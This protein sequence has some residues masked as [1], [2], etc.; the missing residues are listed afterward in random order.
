[1][2]F[3]ALNRENM[4][5]RQFLLGAASICA[6]G[7]VSAGQARTFD[8]GTVHGRDLLFRFTCPEIKEDVRLF[9]IGDT[10]IGDDDERGAPYSHF[11]K[12]MAASYS[13]FD[14]RGNLA[15]AARIAAAKKADFIALVGD[16]VS[17][18]SHSGTEYIRRTM[19]SCGVPWGYVAGNH[20]WHYEGEAGS[21]VDLRAK[22]TEKRLKPLYQGENP[23]MYAKSV[24]GM[25]LLFVDD[26]IYQ[27]LPEQLDFLKHELARGEPT[28]LMM[29]V[30]VFTPGR[31][32]SLGAPNWG[33]DTDRDWEIERRE[34][35]PKEGC[36]ET[37]KEFCRLALSAPNMLGVFA[38]HHHVFEMDNV[39]GFTQ[40]V[41][42]GHYK[43]PDSF[44]DISF[45]P[46]AS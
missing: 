4:N 41:T 14:R 40:L 17:Y 43:A 12:R 6:L 8:R 46:A 25:R 10:H 33:W 32:I 36:G 26:S 24:K 15:K 37:T 23:L 29:H 3:N 44:L 11:S 28:A 39:H 20:D 34:R 38:G 42:P 31:G 1:M 9:V 2:E 45:A 27:I 18:P 19:D 5:R 21:Q 30:P 35:W 13:A 7:N 16:I 22:W